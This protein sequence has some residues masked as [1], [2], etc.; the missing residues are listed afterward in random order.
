MAKGFHQKQGFDFHETF[1]P[2]VKPVTVR[3]VFSLAVSKNLYIKQL[4]VNNAILN[5]VLEEEV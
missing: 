3:T 4:D 5:G 1:C 2:M